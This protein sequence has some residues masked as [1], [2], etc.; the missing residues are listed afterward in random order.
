MSHNF[1]GGNEGIK[2]GI[3]SSS[4]ISGNYIET[5][6]PQ[7]NGPATQTEKFFCPTVE[8]VSSGLATELTAEE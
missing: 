2:Q 4:N 7:R 1:Q 3:S 6:L 5:V 8:K